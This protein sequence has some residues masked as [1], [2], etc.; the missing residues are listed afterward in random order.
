VPLND[1]GLPKIV[2][3][4][5]LIPEDLFFKDSTEKN[6]ILD[7]ASSEILYREG[8]PT[9]EDGRAFWS[10]MPFEPDNAY[11]AFKIYLDLG[12]IQGVRRLEALYAQNLGQNVGDPMDLAE[13]FTFYT[14]GPRC[15]AYDLF[16]VAAHQKLR[17]K[18]VLSTTDSH[19]LEAERLLTVVKGY[20]EKTVMVE[21][22]ETGEMH[23]ELEFLMELTP[24]VALDMLTKLVQIQRISLGMPAH[25]LA[26]GDQHAAP[27]NAEV[28]VVLKTIA[29]AGLDPEAS[30]SNL[31]SNDLEMILGDPDTAALAQQLIIRIGNT[32][33]DE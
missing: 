20:F 10:Q 29:K 28:E 33:A 32:H 22:E 18:R 14:W 4:P 19:Y 3:R 16:N 13:F 25:G 6:H 2:Y 7:V 21:D 26:G 15:K 24:K 31:N 1:Y 12:N 23:E 30:T 9:F 8:F 11:A 17:E 5:D 27:P